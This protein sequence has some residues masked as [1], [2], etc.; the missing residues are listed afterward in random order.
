MKWSQNFSLFW[1]LPLRPP[2]YFASLFVSEGVQGLTPGK[3]F[4]IRK[5]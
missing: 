3:C 2:H 4:P 1:R 5:T